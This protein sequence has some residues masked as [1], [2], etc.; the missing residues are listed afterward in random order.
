MIFIRGSAGERI[1]GQHG[2]P[3]R[4]RHAVD[5]GIELSSSHHRSTRNKN[6]NKANHVWR[7]KSSYMV[8]SSTRLCDDD[9]MAVMGHGEQIRGSVNTHKRCGDLPDPP[10]AISRSCCDC[11]GRR[12]R[13]ETG[14]SGYDTSQRVVSWVVR[15]ALGNRPG[16]SGF[17]LSKRDSKKGM[18]KDERKSWRETR[19]RRKCSTVQ[20]A[21][22]T[23]STL[24]A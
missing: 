13:R 6:K 3:R 11:R 5:G 21:S 12:R 18:E 10:L 19:S 7:K 8:I 15:A 24:C 20:T 14:E 2:I 9:D 16:A 22:R 4:K 1:C 17:A 23:K